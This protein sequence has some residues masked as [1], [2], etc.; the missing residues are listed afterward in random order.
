LGGADLDSLEPLGDERDLDHDVAV[1]RSQLASLLHD[2]AARRGHHLGG[3][4]P[5]DHFDDLEQHIPEL[6]PALGYQRGIGRHP[7]D[8]PH[9]GGFSDFLDV[10]GVDEELSLATTSTCAM[11]ARDVGLPAASAARRKKDMAMYAP[12]CRESI[13][14]RRRTRR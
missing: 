4:G 14:A 6:A 2:V 13:S 3:D 5:I 12:A 10:W 9:V 7:I 1:D 11:M 8:D